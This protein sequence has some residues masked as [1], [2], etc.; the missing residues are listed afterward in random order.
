[1]DVESG[2]NVGEP[3]NTATYLT[4]FRDLAPGEASS[5]SAELANRAFSHLLTAEDLA[6]ANSSDVDPFAY[7]LS[8]SGSR[9]TS[10][11]FIGIMID[12]GASRKST[13]GYGQFQALQE[14]DP[15]LELDTSTKGQVNIQFG[16]GNA[17]SIGTAHVQTPIGKIQFHV[18]QADTPFL[19]CLADM[20]ELQVYYNNLRNVLVTRT[21][22][23]PVARQ[24]GHLFLLWDSSLQTYLSES[25]DLNLCYL[26]D[27]ELQHLHR[28]FGHPSVERLQKVL[29]RAGHDTEKGVLE[30]LTKYCH[31]CQKHS[32]SPGRFWFTLRDD[33]EFNYCII[34]DIMYI[35]GDPLLHVVDE[36]TRFQTGRWLQNISAKHTWDVLRMCW[37]DTYLG[38]PDLITSDA[39]KN[40]VSKEFKEYANTV[41]IR[42]KA[43]PV[44]AHNSIG[45][46]ERYHGPL[47]RVYQIIVVE[48]PGIDRDAALQMAFKALNDTAGPD[49]LVPT[50]LVFGAYS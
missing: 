2:L 4:T 31:Y 40:F 13:A 46:V 49:G 44:E 8:T 16:I 45:M 50:L 3:D 28:R 6:E 19:L 20:D 7:S 18:V 47:R 25:F 15:T 37:I 10:S 34:V 38:P 12:T 35:S 11:I 22:E 30:H 39:G 5:A 24:F 9:Y 36:G 48:L 14:T 33:V 27:V 43:V 29:D 17:S 41:G 23:V 32:R 42:T 26:T 1:V 21:K